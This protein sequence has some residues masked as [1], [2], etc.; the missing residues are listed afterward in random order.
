MLADDPEARESNSPYTE[1]SVYRPIGPL[2][3]ITRYQ[4]PCSSPTKFTLECGIDNV[5]QNWTPEAVNGPLFVTVMSYRISLYG[6]TFMGAATT[7][8]ISEVLIIDSTASTSACG[9]DRNVAKKPIDATKVIA[10]LLK[11]RFP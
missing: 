6:T 2:A 9:I 7:T 1:Q 11:K 8:L 4:I 3:P 10:N 5:L